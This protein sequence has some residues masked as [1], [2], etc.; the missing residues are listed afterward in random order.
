LRKF[1]VCHGGDVDEARRLFSAADAKGAISL[2]HGLSGMASILRA[3][4]LARLTVAAEGAL[5]DGYTQGLPGLFDE[6]QDAV[7]TL[8]VSID[9]IEAMSADA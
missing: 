7:R 8:E 5:L 1:V 9:Q 3:T 4:E 6:L 2:L